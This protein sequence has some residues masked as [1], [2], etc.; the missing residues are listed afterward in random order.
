MFRTYLRQRCN[1][2][3]HR[4]MRFIS[5]GAG[6]CDLELRLAVELRA[7]GHAKFTID[8]LDLNRA[9]LER[10]RCAARDAGLDGQLTFA[11]GDLNAWN[12]AHE[13]DAV[14]ANFSLHHVVNLE[15]LFQEIKQSLRPDGTLLIADIIGR[16]GHQRWPEAL[17]IVHEFWRGLPPSY[18]FNQ[19]LERYEELYENWDCSLQGFEGIRS[20]DLLPLLLRQFHFNLFLAFGNV[21]DPF[22]DRAFGPNFDATSEWDRGFIDRVHRRDE[23]EMASG[24]LKPTHMLAVV[25]PNPC[26]SK[27]FLN[28]LSPE[29]CVRVPERAGR[30]TSI[31][32]AGPSASYNW[33]AWPHNAENEIKVACRTL[34]EYATR[35]KKTDEDLE[36]LRILVLRQQE[37]FEE[38]TQWALQLEQELAER[39]LQASR[40]KVE[41][42]DRTAWALRLDRQLKAQTARFKKGLEERTSWAVELQ[43][44]LEERTAWTT[45]LR[46]ELHEQ[47]CAK[48]DLQREISS[49]LHNPFRLFMR[50]ITGFLSRITGRPR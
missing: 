50:I 44:E 47:T 24:H 31:S 14:L 26:S 11:Q 4:A 42:E 41:L 38:R 12:A 7:Q 2:D 30:S 6:N 33:R 39:T 34:S 17:E 40:L 23:E 3:P 25:S 48:L 37:E 27:I 16:N 10:G 22:I 20:Q 36:E 43:K 18:R 19:A 46:E 45:R 32:P 13:Y 9:M 15:G 5:L 35:V 28:H 1:R 8:C 21:I 49:Y 29:F